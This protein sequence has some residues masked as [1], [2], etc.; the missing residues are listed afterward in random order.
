MKYLA[1]TVEMADAIYNILHTTIRAVYPKY[2]PKEVTDFFSY[3]RSI[4]VTR[5]PETKSLTKINGF[6]RVIS[7]L[8][9][10]C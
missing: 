10:I 5:L 3:Y 2:Y 9:N 4:R 8:K 6:A 7:A 1:A